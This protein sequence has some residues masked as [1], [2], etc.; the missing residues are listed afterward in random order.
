MTQKHINRW[1]ALVVTLCTVF[2]AHQV[3]KRWFIEDTA[4]ME[5]VP[6]WVWI[7]GGI[8]IWIACAV[9]LMEWLIRTAV[10]LS[11]EDDAAIEKYFKEHRTMADLRRHKESDDEQGETQ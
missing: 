7:L 6:V 8:A 4:W 9:L 10:P 3:I 1:I 5:S 11:P 2:A